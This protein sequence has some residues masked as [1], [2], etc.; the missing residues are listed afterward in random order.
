ML[1][2]KVNILLVDDQPAKLLTYRTILEDVGENL[3]SASNATEALELLLRHDVA[4]VLIDVYMPDIDGFQLAAMI[5]N[6]PR[7]REDCADFHFRHP[8]DGRRSPAR[9]RNGRSRLCARSGDPGGPARQS[10]S[11]RRAVP[12]DAAAGAIEQGT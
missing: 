11:I 5:R 9:L 10:Q 12:Q 6:H 1:D 7:F 8:A 2:D 3:L 4:V